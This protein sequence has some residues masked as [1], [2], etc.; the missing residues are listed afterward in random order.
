M[1]EEITFSIGLRNINLKV[2]I[3][4]LAL[5]LLFLVETAHSATALVY[6]NDNFTIDTTTELGFQHIARFGITDNFVVTFTVNSGTF[7]ASPCSL[8][9][10]ESTGILR[11]HTNDT[12]VLNFTVSPD[13]G[14]FK[15]NGSR[16][17]VGDLYTLTANTYYIFEWAIQG[18]DFIMLSM[19]LLG[20]GI[21]IVT[22]ILAVHKV[23]REKEYIW[24]V[25]SLALL[26]VGGA[27]VASWLGAV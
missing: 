17:P 12:C 10:Y 14:V 18:A 19:G 23:K 2:I 15:I 7:N 8:T 9:M 26:T 21:I 13:W 20:L 22:P 11:V 16:Y 1:E 3:L 24:I 6:T 25:Y 5:T 27:F 4:I